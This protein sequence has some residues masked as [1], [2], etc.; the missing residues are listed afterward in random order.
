M[1][2]NYLVEKK[3]LNALLIFALPIII[4]NLFQQTY[5]MADSAIVGRFVSEQALAAVGA[6]Y[7]LTNIFICIAMGGGIG[8]SVTVSRYF[9][10]K[11]YNKMKLAV[12][13]SFISF[14][15][16]S[17]LLGG[18]G[19][20]F[21]KDIMI[22]MNTPRDV[23]DMSVKYLN[24]YFLGLPFLFMYN[25]LSCMF[26]ALGKS[27]IPLYFLIFSSIFNIVLDFI[28]VTQF[29]MGVTGVAW[30]TLIAQG[31]SSVLSFL[32]FIRKLKELQCGHTK[33][34]DKAELWNITKIALPSIFQQ[35]T[36]SIGMML[37][38]S[39]VNSFGS[40]TL[41][42]FSA[43]MRIESICVVPMAGIGNALSSYTA[44]N[45]GANKQERV[46]E[47]HYI[48]NRMVL[49]CGAIICFVL[50]CFNYQIISL[51]LGVDGTNVAIS[52]GESY[53]AFMGWFFCLLG[54]K[55]SVDGLLR[56]AGDMKMFTIANIVN[57][58]IRVLLSVTLAPR[59]GV[60]MVWYAVPIGWLA[61]WIISSVQYSRG[62]WK[63]IYS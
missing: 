52:T 47:G 25:V 51:F 29:H 19:L 40:E 55:M 7:S 1:E 32:V 45:I 20:L 37:V 11:E 14:L 12:F 16:I 54:F 35:S 26:N 8:A 44:Q 23:L 48:A 9:G 15:L 58:F 2:N 4:G 46:I 41:A 61:N 28:L 17:I 53:L 62:K 30:A 31:I 38:Q 56:G 27:K 21:S 60:A 49:V 3:P 13:T 22:L 50:Q 42:G 36:V 6:S 39:V 34:F 57:L 5:T 63:Q 33:V 24:I 43:A 59:Y 18:F 10:S